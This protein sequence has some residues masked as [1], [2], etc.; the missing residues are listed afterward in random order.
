MKFIPSH[1][2]PAL[3]PQIELICRRFE[4]WRRHKKHRSPIPEGLWASA[5]DLACKY[6]LAKTARTLG[7][8]YYSLKERIE[9][10][11]RQGCRQHNVRPEFVELIPQPTA[12]ISECT[13][14]M[15]GPS[16]ARMRIHVKGAATPDLMSLSD[17]SWRMQR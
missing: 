3:P 12:A 4:R 14:E 5:A 15:E 17:S 2:P 6:G 1:K 13:V 9:A 11:S 16:G 7:I 8:N 10:G